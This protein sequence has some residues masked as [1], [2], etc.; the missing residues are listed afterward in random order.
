M[1]DQINQE[2]RRE[3]RENEIGLR[4]DIGAGRTRIFPLMLPVHLTRQ[5]EILLL[6]VL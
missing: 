4:K 1:R 6:H 5:C 3:T 2:I